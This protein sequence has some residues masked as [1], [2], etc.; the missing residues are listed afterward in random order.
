MP[1]K[2]VSGLMVSETPSSHAGNWLRPL[3]VRSMI[4][5]TI[6]L[7]ICQYGI[8]WIVVRVCF[9]VVQMDL[10]T[11]GTC[12]SAAIFIWIGSILCRME[13]N[14]LSLWMAAIVNC[15]TVYTSVTAFVLSSIVLFN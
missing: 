6:I 1:V 9:L 10:L 5:F 11:S 14:S 4:A 7:G 2:I 8:P 12:V 13:A 15:L 3:M